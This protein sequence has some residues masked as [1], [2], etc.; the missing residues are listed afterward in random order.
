[1]I[2]IAVNAFFTD[3]RNI[4]KRTWFSKKSFH[5]HIVCQA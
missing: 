1:V 4:A 5:T 2:G 3:N